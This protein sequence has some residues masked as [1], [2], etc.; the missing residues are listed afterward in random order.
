MNTKPLVVVVVAAVSL[1]S[2]CSN[3]QLYDTVQHNNEIECSKLPQ[4]QYE[5]CMAEIDQPYDEYERE[6]QELSES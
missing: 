3:Q 4:A 2:A 6:R 5:E 1:V